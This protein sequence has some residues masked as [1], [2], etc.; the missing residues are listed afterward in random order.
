MSPATPNRQLRLI[1]FAALG[2][3]HWL[4]GNLY[5]AIVLGP[6]LLFTPDQSTALT[7]SRTFFSVSS[8]PFYYLPWS[9]LSVLLVWTALY[10]A[11]RSAIRPLRQWLT[12]SALTSLL[13]LLLTIY[14]VTN[15]NLNLYYST[16]VYD[17]AALDQTLIQVNWLG[18]LRIVC[19]L[20]TLHSL[21]RAYRTLR[22]L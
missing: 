21:Y 20:I 10:T 11:R 9:P 22:P 1:L 18:S 4:F 14:L 8:P 13:A 16:A 5:E 19:L 17:K 6:N 7:A 15:V 12:A 2:F 3:L